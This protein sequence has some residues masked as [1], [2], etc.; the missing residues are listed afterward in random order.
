[1]G[2]YCIVAYQAKILD[3]HV[4][5]HGHFTAISNDLHIY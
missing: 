4:H 3:E 2:A 5:G 1:M